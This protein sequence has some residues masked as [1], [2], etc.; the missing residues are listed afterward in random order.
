MYKNELPIPQGIESITNTHTHRQTDNTPLKLH[1]TPLLGWSQI[2]KWLDEFHSKVKQHL[3]PNDSVIRKMQ[4]KFRRSL[5]HQTIHSN[6][7]K[8]E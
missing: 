7:D 5:I 1:T 2:T 3:N 8:Q 6:G 4:E